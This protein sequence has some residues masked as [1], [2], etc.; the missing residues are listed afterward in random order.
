MAFSSLWFHSFKLLLYVIA[1]AFSLWERNYTRAIRDQ[2][3]E[4]TT[5]STSSNP[6]MMGNLL[7]KHMD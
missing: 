3:T 1:S 7:S 6:L 5:N 2:G 4:L